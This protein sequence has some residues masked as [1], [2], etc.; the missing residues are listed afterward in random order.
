MTYY[1]NPDIAASIVRAGWWPGTEREWRALPIEERDRLSFAATGCAI[2]Y[3]T[4]QAPVD[5]LHTRCLILRGVLPKIA[6]TNRILRGEKSNWW[7]DVSR[8]TLAKLFRHYRA[9][10][11]LTGEYDPWRLSWEGIVYSGVSS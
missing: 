3:P 4:W 7:R 2:A 10:A 8:P 1:D 9:Q 11:R 5:C 6:L